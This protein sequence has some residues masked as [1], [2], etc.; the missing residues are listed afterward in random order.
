M[1]VPD[2]RFTA[3]DIPP[4][5]VFYTKVHNRLLRLLRQLNPRHHLASGKGARSAAP[6]Q[7]A[8]SAWVNSTCWSR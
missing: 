4:P 5:R 7:A 6:R 2:R 8:A 3:A 1:A